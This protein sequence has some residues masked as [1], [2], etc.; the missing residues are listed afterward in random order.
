ML[1]CMGIFLNFRLSETL[2]ENPA[3]LAHAKIL[4]ETEHT[5]TISPTFPEPGK[6]DTVFER[7]LNFHR[8]LNHPSQARN[9]SAAGLKICTQILSHYSWALMHFQ[10]EPSYERKVAS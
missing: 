6:H 4:A 7:S 1:K 8:S 10:P 9:S 3:T 2:G 5:L